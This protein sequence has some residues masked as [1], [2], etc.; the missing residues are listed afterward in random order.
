MTDMKRLFVIICFIATLLAVRA[1]VS[2]KLK[3]ATK[4]AW[5]AIKAK[6]FQRAYA[7]AKPYA[8]DSASIESGLALSLARVCEEGCPDL[9]PDRPR[10]RR[11]YL[12]LA[13][14]CPNK[15]VAA[16][17]CQYLDRM[18]SADEAALT[19]DRLARTPR[20][21]ASAA[22]LRCLAMNLASLRR[23]DEAAA[24]YQE[25]IDRCGDAESIHRLAMLRYR[26]GCEAIT[27]LEDPAPHLKKAADLIFRGARETDFLPFK[28]NAAAICLYGIG[29]EQ[30]ISRAKAFNGE[31]IA[32]V[33]RF[34]Q[35]YDFDDSEYIPLGLTKYTSLLFGRI[36]DGS[37]FAKLV[38]T[39]PAAYKDLQAAIRFQAEENYNEAGRHF[40]L[41]SLGQ[42]PLARYYLK[43]YGK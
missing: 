38:E 4:E 11:L 41:A 39:A 42:H 1:E 27:Q 35:Y 40:T 32:L 19:S 7:I 3:A 23:F 36:M 25:A 14:G 15:S 31:F 22:D 28:R 5:A 2:E 10:A 43:T 37:E 13:D 34:G 9:A 18:Q 17:A 33:S 24:T 29:T 8:D 6:D 16:A 26:L 20:K 21:T 12:A 30:D